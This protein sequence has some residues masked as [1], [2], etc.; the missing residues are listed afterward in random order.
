[1][2]RPM[3]R[4]VILVPPHPSPVALLHP[5][6]SRL[7][8]CSSVALPPLLSCPLLA[9]PT[10][11]RTLVLTVVLTVV[12]TALSSYHPSRA[13]FYFLPLNGSRTY[14]FGRTVCTVQIQF[15]H[16]SCSWNTLPFPLPSPY[17][18]HPRSPHDRVPFILGPR[19]ILQ[20]WH[21]HGD[22]LVYWFYYGTPTVCTLHVQFLIKATVV[23]PRF[24]ITNFSRNSAQTATGSHLYPIDIEVQL[25]C[26][27]QSA[28]SPL[29][30]ISL[31][32]IPLFASV[33]AIFTR[34]FVRQ[35]ILL[36]D[37]AHSMA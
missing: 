14:Y 4:P 34:S 25:L 5:G 16:P 21:A 18:P 29:R 23:S 32:F 35:T 9:F 7:A 2:T 22:L 26:R 8:L 1:M 30:L 10:L 24:S 6:S 15:P 19:T 3:T 31:H 33:F 12:L 36:C 11:P 13:I 37:G 27:L 17:P 28:L 20:V